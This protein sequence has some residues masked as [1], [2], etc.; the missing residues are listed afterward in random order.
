VANGAPEDAARVLSALRFGWAIAEVRG[1][2]RRGP[3]PGEDA[4]NPR[5]AG[6]ALP[7]G[8]ERKWDEQTIETQTVAETL[9]AGLNLDFDCAELTG[10]T[11]H[12][13]TKASA[14]LGDRA[15]ALWKAREAKPPDAG[16]MAKTW[17]QIAELLWAWDAQI[18]DALAAESFAV[19]SGYQLGRG[20]AE[21]YWA[22]DP[23]ANGSDNPQSWEFL[24]GP[25]RVDPIRR[26]QQRL[27]AYLLPM[28]APAIEASLLAWSDVAKDQELRAKPGT[29]DALHG[30]VRVWHDLLLTGQPP[31]SLVRRRS[32]LVRA[33]RIRPVLR[34]FA[35]ELGIG[36]ASVAA[37]AAAAGLFAAGGGNRALA[38][39]LAVLG[40]FGVT[41]SSALAKAKDEAHDLFAELR[42]ALAA[43]LIKQAVTVPPA[44]LREG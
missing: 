2:L 39:V 19:A 43:D 8:G 38:G 33:R 40:F 5:R 25:E 24:L 41:G 4:P 29:L 17:E 6:H 14:Y 10:L 44:R 9:A 26:L 18:Q 37:A 27:S 42:A 20:L 7:L 32:V 22:N 31:E 3:P 28:T 23:E 13:G 12:A 1:R 16:V 34:A 36:F 30:Q 21:T 15:K 11:D 35:P